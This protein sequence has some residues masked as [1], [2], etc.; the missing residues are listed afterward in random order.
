[1]KMIFFTYSHLPNKQGSS[2]TV[3]PDFF[4]PP[5]GG[6]Q[7]FTLIS[8]KFHPPRLRIYVVKKEED[9]LFFYRPRLL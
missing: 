5:R 1:M 6:K 9:E 2:F 3:F 8:K 7:F 4:H